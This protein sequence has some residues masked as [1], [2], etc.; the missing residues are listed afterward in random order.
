MGQFSMQMPSLGGSVLGANQHPTCS[1]WMR[2]LTLT[3][4]LPQSRFLHPTTST[5]GCAASGLEVRARLGGFGAALV[6]ALL[7]HKGPSPQ[8][9]S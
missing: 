6:D 1:Y 9:D 4:E 5:L 3:P 8:H 2:S 7:G